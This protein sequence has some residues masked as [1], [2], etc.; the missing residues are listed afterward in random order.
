MVNKK[1][2]TLYQ[3]LQAL[4]QSAFP[5]KC[6]TCGRVFESEEDFI[7]KSESIRGTSGLKESL[8]DNDSQIVELFRNCIAT[9]MKLLTA[10]S[11]ESPSLA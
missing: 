4:S 1:E 9:W 2:E 10:S 11:W 8:D 7:R 3:G 5:K 6:T